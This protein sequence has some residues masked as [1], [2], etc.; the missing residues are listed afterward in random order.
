V[1]STP[2]GA[3]AI[4]LLEGPGIKPQVTSPF[5][6]AF[7]KSITTPGLDFVDFFI[8]VQFAVLEETFGRQKPLA[9][10]TMPKRFSLSSLDG[11]PSNQIRS[12]DALTRARRVAITARADGEPE[13][14]YT[15]S[16]A[17][18]IGVSRYSQKMF[19]DQKPW[20]D[21]SGVEDDIRRVD[22]VLKERHGFETTIVRSPTHEELQESL[23]KFFSVHGRKDDARLLV[24]YAGHGHTTKNHGLTIGWVVPSDAPDPDLFPEEFALTSLSMRANPGVFR[25]HQGQAHPVGVR[26]LLFGLDFRHEHAQPLRGCLA[27]EALRAA[28][29]ARHHVR[30]GEG[31]GA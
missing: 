11:R 15:G 17:L 2:P 27:E 1:F 8:N 5:A 9:F 18:L 23:R 7:A 13:F 19:P 10:G 12:A 30:L 22:K 26:Q 3:E 21:L 25:V 16:F 28:H 31:A 6:R 14:V 29:A 4:D 24:Y 20:S